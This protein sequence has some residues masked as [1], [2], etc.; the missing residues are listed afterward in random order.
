MAD[1]LS[2]EFEI[3][4]SQFAKFKKQTVGVTELATAITIRK[5]LDHVERATLIKNYTQNSKPA[6]P[7][8]STYIRTFRMQQ[9]SRKEMTS[10]KFPA[11]EG[12]WE[13][14]IKYASYV[15]GPISA[16]AEIHKNRWPALEAAITFADQNI[17]IDFNK[18]M[19]K[20]QK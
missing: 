12:R 7:E 16:Q 1:V 8:G 6:K 3:D 15:I 11:I 5:A 13:A 2:V 17:S 10:T 18:A 20:V 19:K 9:S 14:K 4:K